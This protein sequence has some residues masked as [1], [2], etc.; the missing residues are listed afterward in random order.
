MKNWY[1]DPREGDTENEVLLLSRQVYLIGGIKQVKQV[2]NSI[3]L[4]LPKKHCFVLFLCL[5][6]VCNCTH[7]PSF[8]IMTCKTV[9]VVHFCKQHKPYWWFQLLPIWR[10]SV[11]GPWYENEKPWTRCAV[12]IIHLRAEKLKTKYHFQLIEYHWWQQCTTI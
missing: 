10:C 12:R 5:R 9:T 1:L 3:D 4:Y 8:S 7:F 6:F 11:V 2:Q